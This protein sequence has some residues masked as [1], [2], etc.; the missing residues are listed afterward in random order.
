MSFIVNFICIYYNSMEA[1]I[2]KLGITA[3]GIAAVV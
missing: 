1:F 2:W 3:K